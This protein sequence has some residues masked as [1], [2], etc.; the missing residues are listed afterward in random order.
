PPALAD[1]VDRL[2]AETDE[3]LAPP[4]HG[5]LADDLLGPAHDSSGTVAD[6]ER[7]TCTRK[8]DCEAND[9]QYEDG[10]RDHGDDLERAVASALRDDTRER[11]DRNPEDEELVPD[12]RQDDREPDRPS[13]ETPR[14]EHREG[15]RHPDRC[16]SGHHARKSRRGE[17]HPLRV[18]VRQAG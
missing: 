16:A 8:T 1:D 7:E 6:L 2:L 12:A 11:D 13:L 9:N 14:L 5:R 18:P 4:L 17:R 10:E 15:A 3:R